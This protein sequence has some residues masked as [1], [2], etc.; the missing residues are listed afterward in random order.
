MRTR[1]EASKWNRRS[2]GCL[3]ARNRQQK[4]KLGSPYLSKKSK[5][6]RPPSTANHSAE[7]PAIAHTT[8]VLIICVYEHVYVQ[9]E[10][11]YTYFFGFFL[12]LSTNCTGNI[13]ILCSRVRAPKVERYCNAFPSQPHAI[14]SILIQTRWAYNFSRRAPILALMPAME[15]S[16]KRIRHLWFLSTMETKWEPCLFVN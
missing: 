14:K 16:V 2:R 15:D 7:G 12:F 1:T 11:V 13:V 8:S 4:P 9:Q 6:R 5:N 3:R 10:Y